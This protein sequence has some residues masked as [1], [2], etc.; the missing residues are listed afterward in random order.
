VLCCTAVAPTQAL[1]RERAY[2]L[3]HRVTL[4]GATFRTD[5]AAV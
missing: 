1:A 3:V 2:D 5:I 4:D